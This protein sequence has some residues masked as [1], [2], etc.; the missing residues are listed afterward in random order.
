MS[1][2]IEMLITECL[3]VSSDNYH[4]EFYHSFASRS[5]K[6]YSNNSNQIDVTFIF[7]NLSKNGTR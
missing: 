4:F 2:L 3:Y 5:T 1:S 7:L 6:N